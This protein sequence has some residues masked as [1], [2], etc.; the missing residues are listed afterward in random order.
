MSAARPA[1][2][3][4]LQKF[5]SDAGVASR[6]RAEEII[7]EGR[8]SINGAT[9]ESL[10]AFVDPQRDRV[11]VDG[12]TVRA[13]RL[14]YFLVHKPAGVVCTNSD[15][16]G[17]PR[18]VDLL[19]P[20]RER[21]FPVGRLDAESS[22]LL[23]LT[24]DGEL[25][26]RLAHPRYSVPKLYRVEVRGRVGD[27][28]PAAMRKGVYLSEGRA[29][30]SEVEIAHASEHGS[31]LLVTL[32][33]SRNR[34][35]RRMLARL[36]FPVRKLKRLMIGPLSV[37]GLPLGAS[38]ELSGRELQQLRD[39]LEAGSA[40]EQTYENRPRPRR[41]R[42]PAAPPAA[43][44]RAGKR[45]TGAAPARPRDVEAPR[46]RKP[47]GRESAPRAAPPR[48][49]AESAARPIRRRVIH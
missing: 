8:V 4:R 39:A 48:R 15:P 38:R 31:V 34:E 25:A 7:L 9:V 44:G 18:A 21:L 47:Y 11:M 12:G 5:L 35:I 40:A 16:D 13:Q 10:P 22:G 28:L 6:R 1:A 23:L 42:S 32:R 33:E 41:K 37:K 43:A 46:A 14:L 2:P 45:G 3:M 49:P 29:Q 36:G 26:Q 24:N 27:A 20:L 19:P 30:A 17:R